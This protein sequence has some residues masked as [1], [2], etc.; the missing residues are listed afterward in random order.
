MG[1]K[2]YCIEVPLNGIHYFH[3]KFHEILPSGSKVISE[4]HTETRS[5]DLISLFSC[6]ESRLKHLI[7]AY[8]VI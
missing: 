2:K 6:F 7:E 8:L 3:T 5:G 4:G 1:L